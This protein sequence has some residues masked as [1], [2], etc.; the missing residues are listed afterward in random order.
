MG[1]AGSPARDLSPLFDP[2]S[3]A[4]LGASA[5][6]AKWGYWLAR[7]ALEGAGEREVYLVNRNG[8]SIF[9][10]PVVQDL[11]EVP[12]PVD[13]VVIA[14][15]AAGFLK[16]VEDSLAVGARAIVAITAGLGELG[17]EGL[18]AELKAVELVRAA[19]AV[20]LG[21]NCLGLVDTGTNLNLA[22]SE[23]PPGPIGLISQSGNLSLEIALIAA[24]AGIGFT[25]MVSVGNQADLD[26]EALVRSFSDH[27]PTRVIAIYA[28]DFRAGRRLAS[29]ALIAAQKNKPVVLLSAGASAA[30]ARAAHSHTGAI[31]S[32]SV[33]V[34]AACRA[35]GMLRVA[36]P[37]ELV[38]L[39]EGLVMPHP[40]RGRR[41][42]VVGDGGGH[43]AIAADLAASSGL[44]VPALSDEVSARIAAFLPVGAATGN[45]VD[46]AGG[47]EQDLFNFERA[48][49]AV[50]SSGAVDA[51]L[52]T[53]YFGGYS[54]EPSG[55]AELE[56][57]VARS[58]A[59][60]AA[61]GGPALVVHSMYP[62]APSMGEFRVMGIP[63]YAD[64]ESAVRVV[65]RLAAHRP[66]PTGVPQLEPVVSEPPGSGYFDARA[67]ISSAGIALVE[68]RRAVSLT[69]ARDAAQELGYPVVLKALVSSHKSDVGAVKLGLADQAGLE[70]AFTE[71]AARW[72]S[73]VFSVERMAVAPEAIEL[74][75]GA[76]RD[77]S[78]GP[79]TMVGIGGIFA[80]LIQDVAVALAPIEDE[81]AADLIR[82]LKGA[83][84]LE[85]ARGRPRLDIEAAARAV[86]AI[87]RIAAD[88]PDIAEIEV[89][90]LLVSAQGA[91][92]LDARVITTP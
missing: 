19:G 2:R 15:P 22:S 40:P 24:Q 50:A 39:A 23:F 49:D 21:P 43:V 79:V 64:I 83:A 51:I 32:A 20:L 18:A 71:L 84:L 57:A 86:A 59:A 3:V 41:L 37:R 11:S 53:G 69:E 31:V 47:G 7:A 26:V 73:P 46:L 48:V 1:E 66:A 61:A 52:L 67:L 74:I 60:S 62:Q 9:G 89:N 30:G 12:R 42:G 65:H 92:A 82:S 17:P 33:A 88:H 90:P 28:E 58:I 80:E 16:A 78:F 91:I 75:V 87:S 63:V 14:I 29:A 4:I 25:R 55:V 72:K 8:G 70:A 5:T 76:I 27:E 77:P 36:T 85:G 45:P 44:E 10:R 38:E 56:Q 6:P 68:A 81:A 34:D 35:S 13:L 54:Y